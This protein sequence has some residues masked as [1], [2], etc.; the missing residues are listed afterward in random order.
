MTELAGITIWCEMCILKM[1]GSDLRG[2]QISWGLSPQQ[3]R[4]LFPG[5]L[6][7]RSLN[8]V[9]GSFSQIYEIFI[10]LYMTC[11]VKSWG[12]LRW[13]SGKES[14]CQC[15]RHKRHRFSPWV[16]KIPWRSEW[17]PTPGFLPGECHGR[18]S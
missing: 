13:Y 1:R 17:Q 10:L 9:R 16:G 14:T 4:W 3:T 6:E 11:V 2:D 5:V 12:L 15:R 18:G 7:M 8:R